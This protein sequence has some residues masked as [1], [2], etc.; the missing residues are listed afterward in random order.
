MNETHMTRIDQVIGTLAITF[1]GLTTAL[2]PFIFSPM[3]SDPFEFPKRFAI[4]ALA[5]ASLL[6][7][8]VRTIIQKRVR[9]T[10]SPYLL[11][12]GVLLVG[13]IASIVLA[14]ANKWSSLSGNGGLFISLVVIFVTMT[15]LIKRNIV[16]LV[17]ELITGSALLLSFLA[18]AD[19]IGI[20]LVPIVNKLFTLQIPN[21]HQ[22]HLTG[23][24]LFTIFVIVIALA[25]NVPR[26]LQSVKTAK[27]RHAVVVAVMIAG[28]LATSIV[29]LPGKP[30][31]PQFLS[32]LDSWS[33]VTDVMKRPINAVVGVGPDS[34]V[35]AFTAF[36]P[37]RLN[38]TP[39]W[40]VKFGNARNILLDILV[41]HGVLGAVA[42][43]LLLLGLLRTLPTLLRYNTS[44]GSALAACALLLAIFP[45]NTLVL[46]LFVILLIAAVTLLRERHTSIK[47]AELTLFQSQGDVQPKSAAVVPIAIGAGMIV[48]ALLAIFTYGKVFVADAFFTE[49]LKA[50]SRNDGKMV[51]D[52]TVKAI[53]LNPWNENYRRGFAVTNISL[54][55]AISQ[56]KTASEQDKQNILTLVQQGIEQ[57]KAATTLNPASASN[58]DTLA[59][60]Y[61]TLVGSVQEAENWAA[62]AF[63]QEIQTDPTN[64]QLRFAL[65]SFYRSVGN[66]DQALKV[67]E[68]AVTLKPDFANAY[69]NMADIYKAKGEKQNQYALL[70]KVLTLLPQDQAEYAKVKA[71]TDALAED[72][73]A[74]LAKQEA[75]KPKEKAAETPVETKVK[76]TATPAPTPTATPAATTT[77]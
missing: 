61:Q 69:Y 31:Q 50:A 10:R 38:Q 5:I 1:L 26:F 72:I 64:P 24:P 4:F 43:L 40:Y 29:I 17:T 60:V 32:S 37:A 11:A 77:P 76:A 47:E 39:F 70:T 51:Y 12:F 22:F 21:E 23:S 44:L 52:Q 45:A 71:D 55:Q 48:L 36:R 46:S 56:S 49:G 75:A 73:K 6:L 8:A 9:A 25:L 59:S 33:I 16:P 53:Q 62:A 20:S 63:I 58:W 65:A 2:L 3:T 54:A 66:N 28:F 15:S 14:S 27:I 74:D 67:F 30:A 68:Q 42:I 13:T 57:A 7:F 18:I 35:D 34:Y 41:T 19:R